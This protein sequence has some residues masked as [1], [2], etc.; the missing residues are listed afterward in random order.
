MYRIRVIRIH[1]L[2][3]TAVLINAHFLKEKHIYQTRNFPCFPMATPTG[4]CI[5]SST[6]QSMT[7]VV[8]K[9]QLVSILSG[10]QGGC[11]K[12]FHHNMRREGVVP[13][14]LLQTHFIWSES[15]RELPC[16]IS[17]L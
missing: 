6:S 11:I 5:T 12:Y 17:I 10:L 9:T 1:F 4:Y 2:L 8:A 16:L 7:Y 15:E 14:H 3:S 13:S